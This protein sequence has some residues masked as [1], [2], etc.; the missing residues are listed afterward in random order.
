VCFSVNI[1]KKAK[2]EE[3]GME[4]MY[5]RGTEIVTGS[6]TVVVERK[7]MCFIGQR[8]VSD[9]DQFFSSKNLKILSP[10]VTSVHHIPIV[11]Q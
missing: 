8:N 10:P 5:G 3:D 11:V 4:G 1:R 9:S 6:V 2:D 7:C